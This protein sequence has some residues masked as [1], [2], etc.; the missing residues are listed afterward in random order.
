MCKWRL[1]YDVKNKIFMN[2]WRVKSPVKYT[3]FSLIFTSVL[4][5]TIQLS[6]HIVYVA[7]HV[8]IQSGTSKMQHEYIISAEE[9][10]R[11][12]FIGCWD[13]LLICDWPEGKQINPT[14]HKL[15]N[16]CTPGSSQQVV[17]F[18]N[19]CQYCGVIQSQP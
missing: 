2:F 10:I 11:K 19:T 16:R 6:F 1:K 4:R 7:I 9:N 15:G 13:F 18:W 14:P 12:H 8:L 3:C 5:A 17:L